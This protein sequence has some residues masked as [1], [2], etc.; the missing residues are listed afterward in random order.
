MCRDLADGRSTPQS[1]GSL[2]RAPLLLRADRGG[3]PLSRGA[4]MRLASTVVFR[5][6][7]ERC[8][9]PSPLSPGPAS[10]DDGGPQ[11]RPEHPETAVTGAR[12]VD[13]R[14]IDELSE[15]LLQ[16]LFFI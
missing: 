15:A 10:G 3:C 4:G 14:D 5:G 6:A 7:Q 8:L 11:E 2:S 13:V 1:A 16:I 12:I 9:N